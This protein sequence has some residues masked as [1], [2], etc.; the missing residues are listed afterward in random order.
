MTKI[1]FYTKHMT[2]WNKQMA[3]DA[4]RRY[5][6]AVE[7]MIRTVSQRL[8]N[9]EM[10]VLEIGLDVGISARAFLESPNV[11]DLTSIDLAECTGAIKMIQAQGW[12]SRFTYLHGDST[13]VLKTLT[14]E[15]RYDL[16][17]IDGNHTFDKTK[18]DI[19]WSWKY[20]KKPG[21]LVIDDTMHDRNFYQRD[22]FGVTKAMWHFARDNNYDVLTLS[23]VNGLSLIKKV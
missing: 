21:F 22:V 11:K 23:C 7:R 3:H 1:L 5:F 6:E 19:E 17:F 20:L 8:K 18:L 15:P 14:G 2:D 10:R 4:T 13:E 12:D 9:K 16:V